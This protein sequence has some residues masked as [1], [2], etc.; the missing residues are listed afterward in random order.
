LESN[1]PPECSVV[2]ITSSADFDLNLGCGIDR[3]AAAVVGDGEEAV[4]VIVDLD[5]AGVARH[6]LV[7]GVVEGLGEQMVQRFFVGAADIHARPPPYRLQPLQHLDV[8]GR[9]AFLAGARRCD[10]GDAGLWTCQAVISASRRSNRSWI[11]GIGPLGRWRSHRGKGRIRARLAD[12]MPL[13]APAGEFA[14]PWQQRPK[15]SMIAASKRWR[16]DR[17]EP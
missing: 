3:D 5:E 11:L 9:I 1:L 4:G 8:G 2:M 14:A 6:R 10:L 16:G 17:G 12:S 15:R 13:P 7:H